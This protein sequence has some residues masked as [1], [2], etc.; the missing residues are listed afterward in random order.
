MGFTNHGNA[1][2]RLRVSDDSATGGWVDLAT[3][4]NYGSGTG[5]AITFTGSSI[6][7]AVN[8]TTAYTDSSI[9][10]G[11]RAPTG[12]FGLCSRFVLIALATVDNH[13]S[14]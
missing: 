3:T 13:H 11:L 12:F 10:D 5:L 9:N 8:G 2:A 6:V 14:R 1:G 4:V 7:Y